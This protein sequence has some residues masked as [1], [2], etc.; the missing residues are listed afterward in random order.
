MFGPETHMTA[1]V[2]MALGTR[3]IPEENLVD[4]ATA[5]FALPSG[6]ADPNKRLLHQQHKTP[7][8]KSDSEVGKK[9]QVSLIQHVPSDCSLY[10]F[11]G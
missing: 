1:I 7:V 11:L 4:T 2:G 9:A 6:E 5:N 3:S 8:T 10:Y